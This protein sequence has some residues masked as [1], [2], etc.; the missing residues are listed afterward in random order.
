M[1][2]TQSIAA[3]KPI[4]PT[5]CGVPA[6]KRC[7]GGAKVLPS[8]LTLSIIGVSLM[9]SGGAERIVRT[10]LNVF[11]EARAPLVFGV[12]GFVL[13]IPIFFDTVYNP[14]NTPFLTAARAAGCP[15]IPGLDMLTLQAAAQ[16][17]AWSN[18][19]ADDAKLVEAM[20]KGG[21]LTV[22][23]VSSR[24]TETVD[25]FSLSGFT[26]AMKAISDACGVK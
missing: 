4:A 9:A 6:S 14:A 8:K 2:R 18:T 3:L 5:I 11:G 1:A 10:A 19:P 7:G 12:S 16:F 13:G 21:K 26:A 23:G 20:R 24:G 17:T 15:T 25:Q 22:K